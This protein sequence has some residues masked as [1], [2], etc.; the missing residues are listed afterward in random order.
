LL[1]W[2]VYPQFYEV[3]IAHPQLDYVVFTE[4]LYDAS[5]FVTQLPDNVKLVNLIYNNMTCSKTL[6]TVNNTQTDVDI[7]NRLF[8]GNLLQIFCR[9]GNLPEL[10]DSPNFHIMPFINLPDCLPKNFVVFHCL[11]ADP[12]RDWSDESWTKL[13]EILIAA[14]YNVVELGFRSVAKP[15]SRYLHG[16]YD[17]THI[18][19]IQLIANIIKNAIFFIGID[20][21]LAHIANA[22]NINGLIIKGRL[23]PRFD[24]VP[25]SGFYSQRQFLINS[26]FYPAS[27]IPVKTVAKAFFQNITSAAKY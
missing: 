4:H 18:N 5:L 26:F 12:I 2:A 13:S 3:L 11:S 1:V 21:G 14:G 7:S 9:I 8:I 19:H 27:K 17:F 10:D 6:K 20:S 25:F 24:Y 22:F 16:Y 23:G 15:N